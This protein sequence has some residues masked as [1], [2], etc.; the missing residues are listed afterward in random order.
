MWKDASSED[1]QTQIFEVYGRRWSVLLDLPYW[2]PA[3]YAVIDSMH[4]LGLGLFQNHCRKLFKIDLN[5]TGGNGAI[6]PQPPND[7]RTADRTSLR[8]C[9]EIVYANE[10]DM[11]NK[12]L[13]VHRKVLYTVCIDNDIRGANNYLVVG[14]RWVLANNIYQW[15]RPNRL[16]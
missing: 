16:C 5:V 7:K 11:L 15:V 8:K 10:P 3:L 13:K 4:A 12:L 9:V 2:N 6:D 1:E 14:T